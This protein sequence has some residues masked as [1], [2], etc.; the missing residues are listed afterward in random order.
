LFSRDGNKCAVGAIYLRDEVCAAL[1]QENCGI[2]P[3]HMYAAAN[4]K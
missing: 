3:L 4:G 2:A 1:A